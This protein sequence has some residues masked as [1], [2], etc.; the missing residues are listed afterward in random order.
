M[1][2]PDED[3]LKRWIEGIRVHVNFY[4]RAKEVIALESEAAR[5][6]ATALP[7]E[8]EAIPPPAAPAVKETPKMPGSPPFDVSYHVKVTCDIVVV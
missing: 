1:S 8:H 2:A 5:R 7:W 3:N 4:M 6:A